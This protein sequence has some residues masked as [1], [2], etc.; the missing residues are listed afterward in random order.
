MEG[1]MMIKVCI[2]GTV[3]AFVICTYLAKVCD[4]ILP[5]HNCTI[6]NGSRRVKE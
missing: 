6:L 4:Y 2:I 3:I 1:I 5:I